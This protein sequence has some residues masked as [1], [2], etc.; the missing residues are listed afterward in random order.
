MI[1]I[2]FTNKLCEQQNF[3]LALIF[4]VIHTL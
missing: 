1:E 3:K 2:I 4:Q